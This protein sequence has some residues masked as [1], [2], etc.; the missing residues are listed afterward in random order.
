MIERSETKACTNCAKSRRKCGKQRPEC[1]RCQSRRLS[2]HYPPPRLTSFIPLSESNTPQIPIKDLALTLSSSLIFHLPLID[3][4]SPTSWFASPPTWFIDPP[5]PS[6]LSSPQRFSSTDFNYSLDRVF[7][8]LIQWVDT[9]ACPFIHAQL[10]R[11][12]YPSA[13]QDAYMAMGMYLRKNTRNESIVCRIIAEKATQVVAHGLHLS[14]LTITSLENLART[15]ALLIYQCI[16]LHDGD[17]R[18]RKLA[19]QHIPVLENWL[20]VLMQQA[21]QTLCFRDTPAF[22]TPATSED[23]M[24][25]ARPTSGPDAVDPANHLWFSWILAESV[26]RLWLITAGLQGLYKLFTKPD[27]ARPCMGGTLFTSRQGFWEASSAGVWER[28]CTERYA[29]LVRLTEM[30]KLF[31][32][33]PKVELSEFARVALQCAFGLEWCET[34]GV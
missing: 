16:C 21:S 2:C 3:S 11:T 10:Y 4:A 24:T 34:V 23:L 5:P 8:W 31:S 26:R 29:G 33:V 25:T 22:T 7:Q 1:L 27:P 32:M 30:D 12:C 6:L 28:E 9:G 19:E 13:I 17:L 15:Q 20:E 14:A 18:L